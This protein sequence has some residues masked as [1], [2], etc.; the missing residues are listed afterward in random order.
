MPSYPCPHC[1]AKFSST[2]DRDTH[3][4][5]IHSGKA[6][7]PAPASRGGGG[8]LATVKAARQQEVRP[9][10]DG[11]VVAIV[12]SRQEAGPSL[13]DDSYAPPPTEMAGMMGS[14][15]VKRRG[16]R[17][18]T[19]PGDWEATGAGGKTTPATI[20]GSGG[21]KTFTVI[22][23]ATAQNESISMKVPHNEQFHDFME[24][25][26]QASIPVAG[27]YMSGRTTGFTLADGP[28]R[29][30]LVDKKRLRDVGKDLTSKLLYLAMVSELVKAWTPWDHVVVW[31][32]GVPFWLSALSVY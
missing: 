25:M 27:E 6:P 23:E 7:A 28:W 19:M 15:S 32:V 20:V 24:R 26:R 30:A 3:I 12:P 9:V 8:F 18:S 17:A 16:D 13:W 5:Y 21:V 1:D 31:H 2:K 4:H 11:G 14:F 10:D 22:S 29:Y